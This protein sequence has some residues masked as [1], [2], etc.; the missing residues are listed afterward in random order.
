M[1]IAKDALV[2]MAVGCLDVAFL[3]PFV[4][5]A[6][7]REA[8]APS[9][10]HAVRQGKLWAGGVGALTMLV[11]YCVAVEALSNLAY[12]ESAKLKEDSIMAKLG[13]APLT[14]LVIA[15]GLQPIEKKIVMDSLLQT[16]HSG[17]GPINDLLLYARTNGLS[18]LILAG[19]LPLWA[20]ETV[21]VAAVTIL[22]PMMTTNNMNATVAE[23]CASAF[24][25]GFSAGMISAP[26]QTLNVL[27]KDD[28]NNGKSLKALVF[29]SKEEGGFSW[30]RLF[31]GSGSRSFRT[32]SAGVLWF[33]A[34]ANINS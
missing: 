20:R 9:V 2:G 26:L 33:L 8:G 7:R 12:K 30:R 1:T 6:C 24:A 22:N 34:R 19:L 11:P 21:Y 15:M 29:P 31:F 32:G 5:I 18:R 16:V 13:A 23:K 28:R 25:I 10:M 17:K 27:Q 14:S 3:W 4:V